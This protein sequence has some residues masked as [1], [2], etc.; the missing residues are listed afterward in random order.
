MV[1]KSN[2][3]RSYRIE[4]SINRIEAVTKCA[5]SRAFTRWALTRNQRSASPFLKQ[6]ARHRGSLW[7]LLGAY[8][9]A[10]HRDAY[11]PVDPKAIQREYSHGD[12]ECKLEDKQLTSTLR[13]L[14]LKG[15][16]S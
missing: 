15:K 9:N 2:Q 6:T 3:T 12:I 11:T 14:E 8:S 16:E 13:H 5:D 4:V 1:H 10:R 7:E